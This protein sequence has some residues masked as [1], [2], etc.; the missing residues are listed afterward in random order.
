MSDEIQELIANFF[1]FLAIS[2]VIYFGAGLIFSMMASHMLL[3]T[4]QGLL[5]CSILALIATV[6]RFFSGHH[7]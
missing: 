3:N 2:L 5:T 4:G 1:V 7:D 6:L